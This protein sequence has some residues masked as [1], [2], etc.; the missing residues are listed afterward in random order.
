VTA[1]VQISYRAGAAAR[2][3]E[4]EGA[5]KTERVERLASARHRLDA[6]PVVAL[7]QKK[8]VFCPRKTSASNGGRFPER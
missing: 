3:V 7:I 8:P 4:R 2:R 6:P 5:G 1:H